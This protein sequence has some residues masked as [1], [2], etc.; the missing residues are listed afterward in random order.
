M[1]RQRLLRIRGAAK[2]QGG[3]RTRFS[4]PIDNMNIYSH[5]QT[6]GESYTGTGTSTKPGTTSIMAR[7]KAKSRAQQE[8]GVK[9]IAIKPFVNHT[10]QLIVPKTAGFD[11][12]MPVS[13]DLLLD[14]TDP[15]KQ[16]TFDWRNANITV[17][18]RNTQNESTTSELNLRSAGK[19][20]RSFVKTLN[21]RKRIRTKRNNSQMPDHI[22]F[23]TSGSVIPTQNDDYEE[24]L[25]P[26]IDQTM[27]NGKLAAKSYG[28]LSQQF[29][30]H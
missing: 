13:S 3:L 4:M 8:R 7:P 16:T 28:H 9:V 2:S 22:Y 23:N 25:P 11:S 30:K 12:E 29:I 14:K 6:R 1:E 10:K 15:S 19:D 27:S 20:S 5:L 18:D 24:E 26:V 17:F 21:E